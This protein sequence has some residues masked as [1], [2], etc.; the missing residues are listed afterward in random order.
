VDRA[1]PTSDDKCYRILDSEL[2][3][4]TDIT[5]PEAETVD[6]QWLT[7]APLANISAGFLGVGDSDINWLSIGFL[8]SFGV[9]APYIAPYLDPLLYFVHFLS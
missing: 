4:I 3:N 5:T 7:Y 9:A 8:F 2:S 1:T 6:K